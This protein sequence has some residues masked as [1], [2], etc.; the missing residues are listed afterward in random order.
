MS[1]PPRPSSPVP[2]APAAFSSGS[3][4]EFAAESLP[5][6]RLARASASSVYHLRSRPV[7]RV[8]IW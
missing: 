1:A 7:P 4:A 2:P 8:A 3:G 6:R 5:K